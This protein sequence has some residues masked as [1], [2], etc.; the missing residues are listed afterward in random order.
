LIKPPRKWKTSH[1]HG[2]SFSTINYQFSIFRSSGI[3]PRKDG[4][5]MQ[6]TKGYKQTEIGIIPNDWEVANAS[7]VCEL[8]VDCKNRTPPVVNGGIFAVAR[9]PNV[10]DG[11]FVE[12]EL[13]FTDVDSYK[14]WTARATPQ[15][16]DILITR[17]APTGEAC[18][19]PTHYRICLG[20]R[21]MMYRPAQHKITSHFLLYSIL[22]SNVQK[23]LIK[24]IGGSTVGHAK[25]DDIRDLKIP[26]PPTKAE[27][28]AIAGALSDADAW[29]ESLEQL[30]AKKRRIKEGASQALLTG[31]QRLPGFSGEWEVKT[32]GEI[33][34]FQGGAGFPLKY[35]GCK[36]GEY[37]FYKVSDMNN[38]GN[39]TSMNRSNNYLSGYTRS[40]LGAKVHPAKSIIFAKVGAAI[41]LERK[42]ILSSP[43]C[44]DNN[45]AAFVSDFEKHNYRFICYFLLSIK[46]S[47]LVATTALP[48]LGSKVLREIEIALPPTKSEQTAIAEIL[49]DMDSELDALAGKLSKARQIKQGMMQELLTGKTRLVTPASNG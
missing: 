38:E 40:R 29:I 24:Q 44:I 14:V 8:I 3:P 28:E 2:K 22:S 30:I 17:E 37:P 36:A 33:G 43:S 21:M 10:R 39:E 31:K 9:T 6:L 23:N 45:L 5:R 25:V 42:K 15:E 4:I 47:S 32:L 13:R 49:S 19:V 41:F 26:L 20:Q 11:K 7:N 34:N 46:L 16:G 1:E 18:L 35:Q 48:S 12:E 27:Q